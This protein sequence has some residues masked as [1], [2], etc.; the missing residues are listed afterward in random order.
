MNDQLAKGL[1]AQQE[2][3]EAIAGL[4]DSIDRFEKVRKDYAPLADLLEEAC[5][6][7]GLDKRATVELA[8]RSYVEATTAVSRE[9]VPEET[10]E[11]ARDLREAF[12]ALSGGDQ[13]DS[14]KVTLSNAEAR[15]IVLA[16][17]G[18]LEDR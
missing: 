10:L 17:S 7:S 9:T 14:Y 6:R 5:K 2:A 8:L 4:A 16:L 18:L 11:I 13:F 1:R 3:R 15:L 12:D